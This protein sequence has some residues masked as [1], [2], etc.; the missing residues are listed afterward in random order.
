M[1]SAAG[2]HGQRGEFEEDVNLLQPA[3]L[4]RARSR[5]PG[6][7]ALACVFAVPARAAEVPSDSV[8]F[9]FDHVTASGQSVFVLGDVA[10]L[11]GG[12]M[13]R[14]LKLVPA[15]PGGG[16]QLWELDVAIPQGT[17]YTYQ[18]VL[19]NDA[20]SQLANPANGTALT[21]PASA[22]TT[23]PDPPTRDLTIYTPASA[24]LSNA[25]FFTSIGP[26]ERPLRP[27]PGYSDLVAATLES[28]PSGAGLGAQLGAYAI[29][30]PLHTI[31]ARST[32]NYNY[33]PVL[34]GIPLDRI[35]LFA[36]PT[37]L[38]LPTRT[39]NNVTGRG[40]Q[41]YLPR[42]YDQHADRAYPV[43]YMH[44]GQ[45]VFGAGG[46]FGSWHAEDVAGGLISDAQVRE[47][48]IVAIDN[49]SDR[50]R[51]YNPEYGGGNTQNAAY[52]QF[53]VTELKPYIDAQYRTRPGRDDTGVLGSS[54][55]GVA[56]LVL[57]LEFPEVFGR[58]G[59]MSTSFWASSTDDRLADGDLPMTTRLYLDAGD[60]ND[61]TA[62]TIAARDGVLR[63]GRVLH[64]SFYFAIGY[65]HAHNEAAWFARLPL[66]LRA[67][68]PI[69]DEPNLID[70]P[71]PIEG[72]LDADC[73]VDL[74]DLSALLTAFGA[75]EGDSN[76]SAAADLDGSGCV[77]LADLSALLTNFGRAC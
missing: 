12:D 69:E 53:I 23:T 67:L 28:Q 13:T 43:L 33:V 76:Y 8:H 55:G 74:A 30:T 36:L 75:C 32:W 37:S 52:N 64:G 34:T 38:I 44:D 51:E 10:E 27:V 71:V 68:Y 31:L 14:A 5:W 58:V 77:D 41:V 46:P 19:R 21:A 16:H 49:S 66:V 20:V 54:F 9:A 70:L 57:G 73:A 4:L 39:V 35:E 29:Q 50:L 40:V 42:Q 26:I 56:S 2:A 61:G 47:L 45:N 24:G 11:G 72:D 18:Y 22:A 3:N 7:F 17:A 15:A 63:T 62:D 25:T 1:F 65:G 59:A 6:T 48:I 60:Q